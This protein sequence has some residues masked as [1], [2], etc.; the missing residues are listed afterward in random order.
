MLT[1]PLHIAFSSYT[2]IGL[3]LLILAASVAFYLLRLPSKSQATKSLIAFFVM[4]ALSGGAMILANAFFYWDRLFVPWQDFWILAAGVALTQFAYRFPRDERSIEG[5]VVLIIMGGVAFFAL[6]YCLIFDFRFLFNW[7]PGLNVSDVF[8]LLLPIGTLL[9]VIIFLRR[10]VHFSRQVET[11]LSP[12][13]SKNIGWH[14]IHPKGEDAR[15]F[16]SLGLALSLAFLPGLQTLS[17]F[18]DPFGFILSNIGSILAIIAIALVYFNL[19]PEVTSFMAKL[20]GITLATVLLILTIA[21]AFDVYL[22][23]EEY[24]ADR[25]PITTS[26]HDALIRTGDLF[27]NPLQVAYV[28]SWDTAKPKEA[29]SYQQLY[30]AKDDDIF[31]IDILINENRE[32]YLEAWSQPIA[33]QLSQLTNDEW[34]QMLRYWTYPLGSGQEDYQSYIF[35]DGNTAYEIGFPSAAIDDDLSAMVSKW[36]IVILSSTA[37]VLLIFPRF[38]RRTLM[39]PLGNLLDGVRRVNQRELEMEIP[40]RFNDEIGF[41]TQS[42]NQMVGSLKELTFKLENRAMYL[43]EL[44]SERT[45]DLIKINLQLEKENTEREKAEIQLN[46]QLLY[47]RALAACSQTLLRVAEDESSQHEV[48]NQAL[49]HL[50]AGAKASRAHVFRIFKDEQLG[51]CMGM[52]AEVCAPGIPAHINNPANRK[53]RLSQLPTEFTDVLA[54]GNPYGGLVREVFASTPALQETLLSQTPPLVSLM[55][56]PLFIRE[57]AW[58]FIGFDDCSNR[59]CLG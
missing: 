46:L 52:I 58:G 42:F 9:I 28:I 32:G 11:A 21:S 59:T 39:E 12:S 4:V 53:Y 45:L 15:V 14:L 57:Q 37:F 55:L 30:L 17:G 20:V 13:A 33:G 31:D 19:A 27:V 36:L 44:V 54:K 23:R 3:T 22:A 38:F 35:V 26:L 50:R 40:V 8:Y 51:P 49:E 10:S 18:P 6:A 5:R 43:E 16:R 29:A 24:F 56:F 47:Q 41:L 25:L 1:Y 7:V 2:I 34:R 48:L